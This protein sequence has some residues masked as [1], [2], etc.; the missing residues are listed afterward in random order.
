MASL[1]SSA[2]SWGA[3]G[4]EGASPPSAHLPTLPEPAPKQADISR[5][6]QYRGGKRGVRVGYGRRMG[7]PEGRCRRPGR[8]GGAGAPPL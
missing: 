7:M 4:W 3:L 6:K 5:H 1:E 2:D 8:L